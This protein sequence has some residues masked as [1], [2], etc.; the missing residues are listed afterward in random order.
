M[1]FMRN[2]RGMHRACP[3]LLKDGAGILF[4]KGYDR[5]FVI[6]ARISSGTTYIYY[7]LPVFVLN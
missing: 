4:L 7:L 5:V 2:S 6:H 1:L 3:A